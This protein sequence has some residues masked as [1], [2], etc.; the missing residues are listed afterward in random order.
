MKIEICN[1]EQAFYKMHFENTFLKGK[2]IVISIRS[3]PSPITFT[4]TDYLKGSLILQFADI[5][6]SWVEENGGVEELKGKTD[7]PLIVFSE[8]M[9]EQIIQF[10]QDHQDVET[11]LVH[12]DAGVSRS[13]AV[14]AYLD[15]I[16]NSKRDQASY[17]LRRGNIEFFDI[18]NKVGRDQFGLPGFQRAFPKYI[19]VYRD[20]DIYGNPHHFKLNGVLELKL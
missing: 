14:G 10:V 6:P 20:D 19:P 4:E 12:C 2:Y 18:L 15:W 11:I 9:A 8:E 5:E 1:A 13:R 16:F 17:R 3:T 7:V